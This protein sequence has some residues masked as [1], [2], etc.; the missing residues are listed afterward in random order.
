MS[1]FGTLFRVTTYGESHCASV[2]AIIDGCPPGL[3]LSAQD[4]QVQLSRRRPGQSD[5]TTPRNEKDFVQLQSG[6][7][8]GVT[9]GTP[10][11]L[12]VKNEDQ[13]P[14][15]YTETD[16]Y[17]R[18]SHADYTYLQK[19][20]IKASSGGGRSSARE[21]IGRVAAGAI[22]EKY[23]KI[24]YGIEIVAFVSSVGKVHLPATIAPPSLTPIN[25]DEEDDT[26][27]D[28]LSKDLVNLLSTI[29]RDEV[30]KY[31]TRC[32]HPE[33]SERMIK[34][35]IRAKDAQDS[36]GGTVTCVIR[37]VPSGLGEPVF[38]KF[39][40]SL[41][42]AMLSIPATKAFEIGSGF[43]GTEVPGSQHNDPF[44]NDGTGRL[45]TT[46][47]W[48]GGIQGGITNGENV[49]F[50]IGFKSPATIS[51]AQD[52]AKYDG[53]PGSLAARGRHDPCVV[54]RAV[55]IVEAMAAIVV[56][57]QLLIQNS[58]KTAANLLPPI[59]TLPPTMVMPKKD[60]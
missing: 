43:R 19:Y 53:T 6:I 31:P 46:S 54:P 34:R 56:M 39:E 25:S 45:R 30:D 55:P 42:H 24:V 15:D 27:N 21:T 52:T 51:Q 3:E 44:V 23:L 49:Y 50:R 29:S 38:D 20:G 26:A 2:G 10:I 22:A 36:I 59:T 8:Q 9:L 12:L 40:A 16:L 33:T 35:I 13:R 5:L 57:D 18:P 11:A 4:I 60:F 17:P 28:A 58:R 47:N 37:N 7:E 32:P 1:T 48:S 41:A 14:H